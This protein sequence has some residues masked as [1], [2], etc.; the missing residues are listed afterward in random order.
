MMM[1]MADDGDFI[2]PSR[3]SR[4]ADGGG[5]FHAWEAADALDLLDA[6]VRWTAVSN[7]IRTDLSNEIMLPL[8]R[9]SISRPS[10]CRLLSFQGDIVMETKELLKRQGEE[11]FE[12]AD[13]WQFDQLPRNLPSSPWLQLP[14]RQIAAGYGGHTFIEVHRRFVAA[15]TDQDLD[16]CLERFRAAPKRVV[17]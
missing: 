9:L 3:V 12:Y 4:D 2:D 11:D 10:R 13:L 5:W 6:L 8:S 15:I 16:S 17:R 1:V 14:R 7:V